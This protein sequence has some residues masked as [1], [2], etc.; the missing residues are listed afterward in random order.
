MYDGSAALVLGISVGL[1]TSEAFLKSVGGAANSRWQEILVLVATAASTAL[2]V[3]FTVP[4][5]LLI[6]NFSI[7]Y[8]GEKT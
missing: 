4:M 3:A 2:L 5:V 6:G 1:A 8:Y 7:A